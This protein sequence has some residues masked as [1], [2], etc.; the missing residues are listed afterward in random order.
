MTYNKTTWATGDII[1][2]KKLNNIENEVE[3]LN[4]FKN[5]ETLWIN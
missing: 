3:S 2:A 5:E 1:T 4:K